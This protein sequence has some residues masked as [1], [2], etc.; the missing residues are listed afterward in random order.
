M[1]LSFANGEHADFV[2]ES[3]AASLGHA[4]GNTLV[5]SAAGVAPWH[6]RVTIDPRGAVLDILDPSARTHVNARPVRE[7]ALLRSGDVVCLGKVMITLKTDRDDLIRTSLPVEAGSPAQPPATPP[8]VILR[9]V[10]GSHFGKAIAVNHRVVVGCAADCD[11][12]VDG[13]HVSQHHAAIECVGEAIYLRSLD[14]S[15]GASVNGVHVRDAVIHPG[16]QIAFER[17][18]FVVEAPGLPLRGED[19]ARAITESM[20]TVDVADDGEPPARGGIWWLIGAAALI[21]AVLVLLIHRGI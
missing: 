13:A 21:A 6:A 3:G 5:L 10:S 19:A 2:L 7:K 14:S 15:G 18:H 8:R 12:V 4:Q 1:R 9:G 17:S 20:P 11:L 16:D